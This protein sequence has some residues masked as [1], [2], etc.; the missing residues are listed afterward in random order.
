MGA[1]LLAQQNQ[2]SDMSIGGRCR[3]IYIHISHSVAHSL[4]MQIHTGLFLFPNP[5]AGA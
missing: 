1:G 3:F 5:R 4:L 2:W